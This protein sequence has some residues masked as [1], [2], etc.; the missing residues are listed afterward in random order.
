MQKKMAFRQISIIIKKRKRCA[1]MN[2]TFLSLPAPFLFQLC[3]EQKKISQCRIS[4]RTG[5]VKAA[6]YCA[7]HQLILSPVTGL[8]TQCVPISILRVFIITCSSIHDAI[9]ALIHQDDRVNRVTPCLQL[10]D[11]QLVSASDLGN[12]SKREV[13][14]EGPK[15]KERE[16]A[17]REEVLA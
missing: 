7:K 12:D 8:T 17:Q 10:G 11:M 14:Q 15:E 6:G 13:Q 16:M 2:E 4:Y 3:R 1:L 9:R 5:E